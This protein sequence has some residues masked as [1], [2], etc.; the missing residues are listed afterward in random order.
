GPV[1]VTV[2]GLGGF[3][4]AG[5]PAERNGNLG[6]VQISAGLRAPTG[7]GISVN[8][9]PVHGGGFISFEPDLGR[10]SGALELSIYDVSVK[11]FGLI[12]TKV[13]GVSFSFVVVISTEFT[14]IQLG[15][16]F[17]L[18]G[19]GGLVG[20]NR[21]VDSTALANLVRA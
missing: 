13:P 21:T 14:A 6:P 10:Y 15:F 9:G 18:N 4:S 3:V 19:V 16:G 7:L 17:T 11:A 20:I 8:S 1:A 12:E 5:F 2:Q